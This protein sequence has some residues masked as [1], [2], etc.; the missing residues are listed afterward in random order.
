MPKKVSKNCDRSLD[1]ILR[2]HPHILA[3]FIFVIHDYSL[4]EIV[5]SDESMFST[6][7]HFSFNSKR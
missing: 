2:P 3:P 6:I 7:K 1:R 4:F 5:N